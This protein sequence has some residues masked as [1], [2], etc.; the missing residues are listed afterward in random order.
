[1]KQ[2]YAAASV[3]VIGAAVLLVSTRSGPASVQGDRVERTAAASAIEP[4]DERSAGNRNEAEAIV[5]AMG[6]HTESIYSIEWKSE[7]AY[8]IEATGEWE[9]YHKAEHGMDEL[10]RWYV[11]A[12]YSAK[13]PGKPI[14]WFM[15]RAWTDDGVVQYLYNENSERGVVQPPDRTA[16]WFPT[17]V[18]FLGRVTALQG[19]R[20][21]SELMLD[22]PDLRVSKSEDAQ[23]IVQV[24]GTVDTGGMIGE[25]TLD[26]DTTR[27]FMIV[28]YVLRDALFLFPVESWTVTKAERV[29][30]VYVP[31]EGYRDT[32]AFMCTEE[33]TAK[34]DA[35]LD[36]AGIVRGER[37]DP[38]D[39]ETRK[40]YHT[41]VR[42]AFGETGT[43]H[44]PV[45]RR[46]YLRSTEIV[47]LNAAIPSERFV[48]RFPEGLP[49]VNLFTNTRED[50]RPLD[51]EPDAGE[52]EVR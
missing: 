6:V 28:Q 20:S 32:S 42:L 26:L 48:H 7:N 38:R 34:I 4:I 24:Q 3:V 30:G 17:P 46:Q 22:A 29:N 8:Q 52:K 25:L 5:R 13:E 43:P 47:S 9:V 45:W 36:E 41:L 50:G 40:K 10:G 37:P 27:D 19:R 15:V 12:N 44:E 51:E 18:M 11:S 39:A 23:G 1:M 49:W 21:I 31:V 2:G 35:A 14:W 33:D 16:L